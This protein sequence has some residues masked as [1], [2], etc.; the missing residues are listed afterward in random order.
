MSP[1]VFKEG[2]LVFWFHSHDVLWEHR[3]SIHVGKGSQNDAN[4][5]KIWLEPQIEI[6][7]EGRTLSRTELNQSLQI[8][9]QNLGRIMEAWN[10]HKRKAH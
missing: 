5:A 6:A 10:A 3:A 9:K 7:R 8:I 1:R 2:E 4:D